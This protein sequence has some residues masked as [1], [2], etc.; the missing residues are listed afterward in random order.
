M[1]DFNPVYSVFETECNN[2][3]ESAGT[4]FKI[5]SFFKGSID[6]LNH[7]EDISEGNK[8]NK[9]KFN[10]YATQNKTIIKE[11]CSRHCQIC[12][13]NPKLL[14]YPCNKYDGR[15]NITNYN[16]EHAIL[17]KLERRYLL[18]HK[19]I[20]ILVTKYSCTQHMHTLCFK[21][22]SKNKVN[23]PIILQQYLD[24]IQDYR[25]KMV[26]SYEMYDHGKFI[27]KNGAKK[28]W[29][30]FSHIQFDDLASLVEKVCKN[31]SGSLTTT[32]LCNEFKTKDNSITFDITCS[33]NNN[34]DIN[35]LI[36][37]KPL[38]ITDYSTNSRLQKRL[39]IGYRR[40]YNDKF[41]FSHEMRYHT[42]MFSLD[43]FT[44]S[45]IT[46]SEGFGIIVSKIG[47]E[48]TEED[49]VNILL[50]MISINNKNSKSTELS[51]Y[52]L[53]DT[54]SMNW[55]QG[56]LRKRTL[57]S[58]YLPATIK[59]TIKNNIES[60]I[61]NEKAYD[62]LGITYKLGLLLYG[63]PGTGKTSL[64]RALAND[65]NMSIYLLDLNNSGINDDNI[66]A[67][68]NSLPD[69]NKYKIL[70]FEDVDAAF[71]DK[72][73]IKNESKTVTDLASIG[74]LNSIRKA[75][76]SRQESDNR[77][78]EDDDYEEDE[79]THKQGS[80]KS[81][82]NFDKSISEQKH[83]TYS[84]LLN[85]FDGVSSNQN[86]VI[87]IMT[88]NHKEKLGSALIRPGRIDYAYCID[89]C[90]QEQIVEMI[91]NLLCILRK[92]V[93]IDWDEMKLKINELAIL[94]IDFNKEIN[95]KSDKK[96]GITPAQI[97]AYVMKYSM[98]PTLLLNNYEELFNEN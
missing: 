21:V 5:Y 18:S 10:P 26:Y 3:I 56:S 44:I 78:D 17:L 20:R 95:E 93:D 73:K 40:Y 7:E 35:N 74:N 91:I 96:I 2:S 70:L 25:D 46:T 66:A 94:I 97:Q 36:M 9:N 23:Y 1:N 34:V 52:K 83:L 48:V 53:E 27:K 22:F 58:I 90:T 12:S 86:K 84:G 60:F 15:I 55:L 75:T 67:I 64:V 37:S 82:N 65:Y 59:E 79:D 80:K 49:L 87:M 88:T 63:P 16:K 41:S 62:T 11:C 6:T 76:N 85:A 81:N 45:T 54:E 69:S 39:N 32:P 71:I 89:Y 33:L 31:N 68:L 72:E 51:V 57:D 50:K 43:S 4:W 92:D 28:I 8:S 61:A 19:D 30:L 38:W 29:Y 77:F 42:L 24:S 14:T 98:S 47:Y 13:D